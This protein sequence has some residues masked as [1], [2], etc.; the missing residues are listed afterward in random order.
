MHSVKSPSLKKHE[1]KRVKKPSPIETNV[2]DSLIAVTIKKEID[3]LFD[4]IERSKSVFMTDANNKKSGDLPAKKPKKLDKRNEEKDKVKDKRRL[5]SVDKDPLHENWGKVKSVKCNKQR[6]H[7]PRYVCKYCCRQFES[8]DQLRDHVSSHGNN[9]QFKCYV[10]GLEAGA[11]SSL[12]AHCVKHSRKKKTSKLN[13]ANDL[14]GSQILPSKSSIFC[15]FCKIFFPSTEQLALHNCFAGGTKKEYK[16]TYC[17]D[18]SFSVDSYRLHVMGHSM[19]PFLCMHCNFKGPTKKLLDKH[20]EICKKRPKNKKE[21][22]F[23]CKKCS[24]EFTHRRE[25]TQHTKDCKVSECK[26]ILK[27]CSKCDCVFN[28]KI[29]FANHKCNKLSG[30]TTKVTSKSVQKR[31]LTDESKIKKESFLCSLCGD[32]F[33]N[34]QDHES[35][36]QICFDETENPLNEKTSSLCPTCGNIFHLEVL[37]EHKKT[38]QFSE[39]SGRDSDATKAGSDSDSHLT[40]RS[41]RLVRRK[42]SLTEE[43]IKMAPKD[44]PKIKRFKKKVIKGVPGRKGRQ[45]KLGNE[46][47][48]CVYCDL[49]F[50]SKSTLMRHKRMHSG[51][52]YFSCKFCG[53][54]F[55]R[56]DV[57]TRHEVNVHSKCS[58]NVFCCYYC[59]LYFMDPSILKEHVLAEHKDNAF[60]PVKPEFAKDIHEPI[61]IKVEPDT[62]KGEGKETTSETVT[63]DHFKTVPP[64]ISGKAKKCGIC[65]QSFNF[66]SE[67]EKH[68]QSS[69]KP[70]NSEV[71][72]KKTPENDLREVSME[73][74]SD[75]HH[76][77]INDF[78]HS[79]SDSSTSAFAQKEELVMDLPNQHEASSVCH[80]LSEPSEHITNSK[81]TKF[82]CKLCSEDF[83]DK[84]HC[85]SHERTKHT[86]IDW[87]QCLICKK[88]GPKQDMME[89]MFTHMCKVGSFIINKNASN[90]DLV[91][92]YT[93]EKDSFNKFP[94]LTDLA[95]IDEFTNVTNK[96]L[97][98]ELPPLIDSE[99]ATSNNYLPEI[100]CLTE[101]H[102]SRDK[103][104][105]VV[106]EI[107]M[108]NSNESEKCNLSQQ[109]INGEENCRKDNNT[110][111]KYLAS[112]NSSFEFCKNSF[113]KSQESFATLNS[114]I[115]DEIKESFESNDELPSN[116]NNILNFQENSCSVSQSKNDED[117]SNFSQLRFLLETYKQSRSPN[118]SEDPCNE[119]DC[120]KFQ[121]VDKPDDNA[122]C[123]QLRRLL[124]NGTFNNSKIDN[125]LNPSSTNCMQPIIETKAVI[126]NMEQSLES[127]LKNAQGQSTDDLNSMNIES[128]DK[129]EIDSFRKHMLETQ[130]INCL[131]SDINQ[132]GSIVSEP[133]FSKSEPVV[134]LSNTSDLFHTNQMQNKMLDFN[135]LIK[136]TENESS[137]DGSMFLNNESLLSDSPFPANSIM[138][139]FID[140][141]SLKF[142]FNPQQVGPSSRGY[143]SPQ[144]RGNS[145]EYFSS[146]K[147]V[148]K[149]YNSC[150]PSKYNNFNLIFGENSEYINHSKHSDIFS[151]KK[152][153]VEYPET[154]H[155]L[156]LR[157]KESFQQ[158]TVLSNSESAS[159]EVS[160]DSALNLSQN[161]FSS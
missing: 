29:A 103:E 93:L 134:S 20:L 157:Q 79:V 138:N 109:R 44:K 72:L 80:D 136:I 50:C 92:P 7:P 153:H 149:S 69:H 57:Y 4:P 135:D 155:T 140:T 64:S 113:D 121:S 38:C 32:I 48:K 120:S 5:K 148:A 81:S 129:K 70:E 36:K 54:F 151:H 125:E 95:S 75:A 130:N 71:D 55:F 77:P 74:E 47:F 43:N 147:K 22:I 51:N 24:T 126:K 34:Q 41:A 6:T 26:V 156:L 108:I 40:R 100:S 11:F 90:L 3:L 87:Y 9:P 139:P 89:H 124:K 61:K 45:S 76:L 12:M 37:K 131:K 78:K 118:T 25:L 101:E 21:I 42:N 114:S 145:E 122:D 112:K 17:G 116:Q 111:T 16:C 128:T 141:A 19:R 82:M 27:N 2:D 123:V 14:M 115:N 23:K 94:I 73:V 18:V 30:K 10:C 49:T 31:K 86:L 119:I 1:I 159:H 53:K 97:D 33:D 158:P 63:V 127:L 133:N 132:C 56:K 143:N 59:R 88:N 15:N 52:P 150:S 39:K 152:D 84:S 142:P 117:K 102:F 96:I 67:I 137:N 68:M 104:I 35:H 85:E 110:E 60:L 154:L 146:P 46:N 107:E 144:K 58:K 28:S 13:Y 99:V 65:F 161:T 160:N 106:S 98:T 91:L 83:I 8:G 62:D 105:P 66:L